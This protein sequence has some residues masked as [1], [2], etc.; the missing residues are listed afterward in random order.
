MKGKNLQ[1]STHRIKEFLGLPES[2][3]VKEDN[4]VDNEENKPS[5]RFNDAFVDNTPEDNSLW[6]S[7]LAKD[8]TADVEC[9]DQ[10]SDDETAANGNQEFVVRFRNAAFSWGKN[11][12]LLEVD[13]LDIPAGK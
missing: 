1:V 10:F 12:A 11:D 4:C 5:D 7:D 9:G 3:N 13:D 6:E 2:N 8:E